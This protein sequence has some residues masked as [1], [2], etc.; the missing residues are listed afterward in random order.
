MRQN[1]ALCGNELSDAQIF[2]G[3]EYKKKLNIQYAIIRQKMNSEWV[4]IRFNPL[5]LDKN[6]G[7]SNFKT[8]ANGDIEA[9]KMLFVCNMVEN[10]VG[11][12]ESTGQ[13]HFLLFSQYF[14]SPSSL[15]W[16]NFGVMLQRF[17]LLPNNVFQTLPN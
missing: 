13:Q 12:G 15:A 6:V 17:N 4:F 11:K 3:S 16:L 1:V 2:D 8:F 10:I 14:Q 5:P 9:A 7:M